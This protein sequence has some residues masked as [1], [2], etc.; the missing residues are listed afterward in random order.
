LSVKFEKSTSNPTNEF[1]TEYKKTHSP[2]YDESKTEGDQAWNS[3]HCE[4][5]VTAKGPT[6][7]K[8]SMTT[9]VDRHWPV[10]DLKKVKFHFKRT[11]IPNYDDKPYEVCLNSEG[12]IHGLR[13]IVKD[14]LGQNHHPKIQYEATLNVGENCGSDSRQVK[15]HGEAARSEEQ[16]HVDREKLPMYKKCKEDYA[17]GYEFSYACWYVWQDQGR[18]D[19]YT[20]DVEYSANVSPKVKDWFYGVYYWFRHKFYN[21]FHIQRKETGLEENHVKIEA[22]FSYKYPVVDVHITRPH[23]KVCYNKIFV[24]S[25]LPKYKPVSIVRSTLD[26]YLEKIFNYHKPMCFLSGDYV[27]T[28]DGVQYKYPLGP[29]YHIAVSNAPNENV[30][31][32]YKSVEDGKYSKAQKLVV[33]DHTVEILPEGGDLVAYSDGEKILT[34]N[35]PA[36]I[37]GN[38]FAVYK[39]YEGYV[40]ESEISGLEVYFDGKNSKIKLSNLYR[41]RQEGMC[42]DFNGDKYH[43]FRSVDGTLHK[44]GAAFAHSYAVHKDGCHA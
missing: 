14:P 28:L 29:C 17:K 10:M 22:N 34:D 7:R 24:P 6:E 2:Y 11:P 31:L 13:E 33:N 18:V 41:G 20:L 27:Y 39:M 12:S 40:I 35:T 26:R 43:E 21:N 5:Q 3:K 42:G 4:L 37:L 8:W 23:E 25:I 15:F 32:M 9:E 44:D 19:H 38:Q 16:D 30:I 36:Y 1:V